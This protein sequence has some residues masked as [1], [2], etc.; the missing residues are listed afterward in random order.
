MQLQKTGSIMKKK[1]LFIPV[2]IVG[3]LIING[4]S[5]SGTVSQKTIKE[6]NPENN[7]TLK[8]HLRRKA[9]VRIMGT[10]ADTRVIIR[11]ESSTANPTNQPLFVIDGQKVGH[12]FANV[13]DM[14]FR[15]EIQFVE[16]LPPSR[17]AQYGMEGH[18]GVIVI[19]TKLGD[20]K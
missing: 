14:L 11:G 3:L 7:W 18:F 2:I 19:H 1:L 6:S 10:G 16:V 8:D 12:S 5:S 13:N 17:S 20:K 4:C 15:G 9:G